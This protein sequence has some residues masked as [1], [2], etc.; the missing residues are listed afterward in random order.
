MHLPIEST[1]F[2]L[3]GQQWHIYSFL[4]INWTT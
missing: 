2:K 3:I 1:Y 4:S